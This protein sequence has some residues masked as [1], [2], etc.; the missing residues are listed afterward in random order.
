MNNFKI[1]FKKDAELEKV[2]KGVDD[3]WST[4]GSISIVVDKIEIPYLESLGIF[5]SYFFSTCLS[6][7]PSLYIGQS[8]KFELEGPF[9]LIFEPYNSKIE[10]YLQ[11]NGKLIGEKFQ[12]NLKEF[13]RETIKVTQEFID[14]VTQLRPDLNKHKNTKEL[15]DKVKVATAWYFQKFNEK[16]E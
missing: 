16:F 2:V 9:E 7:L 12:V 8:G 13:A 6:L 5:I 11:D 1:L 14:Y 4:Y 10:I 3:I 15:Q